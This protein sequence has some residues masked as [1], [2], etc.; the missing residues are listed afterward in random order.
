MPVAEQ[1]GNVI[2]YGLFSVSAN[3]ILAYRTHAQDFQ[4][5]WLDRQGNAISRIGE[6]GQ[7]TSLAVSPDGT[8]AAV[9]RIDPFPGH[10]YIESVA[11]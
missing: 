7:Y 10:Q 2:A 1:V 8:R 4:L 5:A 6:P 9:S 3:G 11:A